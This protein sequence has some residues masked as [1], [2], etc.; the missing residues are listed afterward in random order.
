MPRTLIVTLP[1]TEGGVPAKTRILA[2]ELARRGH[3]VTVAFY[4]PVSSHPH[5]SPPSW[6]PCAK[7]GREVGRCFD[8]GFASVAVGCRWP[9]LEFSYYRPSSSWRELIQSHDRHMAVGGTC[10][11]SYPLLMAAIPHLVW[12]ASDMLGDRLARRQAMPLLRRVLDGMVI[13]PVQAAMEREILSGPGHMVTVGAYAQ[14]MF[15][16]LGFETKPMGTLPI[17]T[18]PVRF[19]PPSLPPNAGLVGF[20]GR[21]NDPRKNIPLLA[22]AIVLAHAID[23]RIRLSLT[24]CPDPALS[25]TLRALGAERL[26]EWAGVL[27]AEALPGFYAGLDVFVIP[28]SQEGF[29]IVGI[30]AMACGVPVISTRCGGPEDYVRD[31]ETGFLVPDDAHA[32]ADRILAV[33]TDR[34]L[35][36]RLSAGARQRAV[37]CY[38]PERFRAALDENWRIVWGETP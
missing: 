5:L 16:R 33:V 6:K 11:I 26:V 27:P 10:L 13:G 9:E 29:G 35:R 17:P 30:E 28:S 31:G 3:D 24:G 22:K 1:P 34:D 14:H 38:S 2:E 37:E 15:R 25:A 20:A 23:P 32:L 8:D 21:P 18:D 12:C 36:A 7:P 19:A 4:A